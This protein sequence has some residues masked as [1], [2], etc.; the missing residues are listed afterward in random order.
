MKPKNS[1]NL[2][3]SPEESILEIALRPKNWDEYIGQE[4]IKKNLQL[5]IKAAKKRQ[6]P[7]EHLLFYGQPGLGKTTLAYIIAKEMGVTI[8]T[9]SGP[10]LEKA[11]DIAAILTNLE[12]GEILFIDEIHR[13]NKTVE[14]ILYPALE[15]RKLHLIIG[16]GASARIISLDLPP[17]TLIGAT[18]KINLLSEALRSRFGAIFHLN[19]Y[20]LEDIE[21]IL[22]RSSKILGIEIEA[23]AISLLAKSSRF[24]PRVANRLLKRCRDYSQIHNKN[25]IDKEVVRKTLEMLE[26]DEFGLESFDRKILETIINKFNGG[27]VGIKALAAALNEDPATI[28]DV[29]EPFLM[30]IG[31]IHRTPAGR[32]ATPAS[33]KYLKKFINELPLENTEKRKP[34]LFE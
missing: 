6:E 12:P 31:F 24:T 20:S 4:K 21:K 7:C 18:T 25:K 16:K 3:I 1:K 11:G 27:P 19:Y 23:E 2:L 15:T 34:N 30:N 28:E 5:M 26:I 33:Y 29:H 32:I 13:I 17:F 10:T 8:K 14:E 22:E 9:A